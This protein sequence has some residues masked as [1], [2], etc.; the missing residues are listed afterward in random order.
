MKAMILTGIRRIEITEKPVPE[1]SQ[2][3]EVLIRIRSVGVCGSDIHYYNEGKIGSQVV[4]FPF[5]LGHE[6][7]G[8]VEKTGSGVKRLKTGD[9]V[10]ID[11]AMPCYNCSQCRKGRYHTCLNLRFLGCPGQAEGCLSEYIVMPERS[12][13]KID[14]TMPFDV[15]TLSEPLSIGLYATELAGNV[16]GRK[17]GILGSG[18]IGVSVMLMAM[19]RGAER[20]FVTDLIDERLSLASSMGAHW[21][22]NPLKQDIVG[23]IKREEPELLDVV[24]ECCGKQEAADQA[25]KLLKPGGMLVIAGIPSFS[26]WKFSAE[27]IRRKEITIRNVRRQNEMVQ[28]TLD[29][30]SAGKINPEKMITHTFDLDHVSDAFELVAGYRDGVMKAMI[31]L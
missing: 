29:I 9:R 5:T 10:A 2:S 21:T 18:P 24:F 27:D 6:C 26:E 30:L 19:H 23:D 16:Q 25:V 17:I 7:S 8:I 14:N 11:P 1:I 12:C 15:A 4:K 3:D 31:H 28:P 20:V 22:G 13:Y